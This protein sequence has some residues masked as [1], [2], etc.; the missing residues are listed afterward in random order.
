[1][2]FQRREYKFFCGCFAVC[3]TGSFSSKTSLK[4]NS[5]SQISFIIHTDKKKVKI[6]GIRKLKA[7]YWARLLIKHDKRDGALFIGELQGN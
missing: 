1:V 5:I 4:G 6:V 3:S 2:H 7:D